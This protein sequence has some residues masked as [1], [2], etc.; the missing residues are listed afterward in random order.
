MGVSGKETGGNLTSSK[1]RVILPQCAAYQTRA[2]QA[3]L[4]LFTLPNTS[5][6]HCLDMLRLA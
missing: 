5:G 3:N 2:Y 1:Y 4:S 6:L